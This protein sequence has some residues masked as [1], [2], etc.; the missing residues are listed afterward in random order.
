MV[1]TTVEIGGLRLSTPFV[2]GSG[3]YQTMGGQIRH[4]V[5]KMADNHW[6]GLVTKSYG[7]TQFKSFSLNEKPYL[8][9][10]DELRKVAMENRGPDV[11]TMSEES[12]KELAE[13]VKVMHDR[14]LVI[15][16]NIIRFMTVSEWQ[17]AAELMAA[18]GVDAIEVNAGCPAYGATTIK[19]M[20]E[21]SGIEAPLVDL[22]GKTTEACDKVISAVREVTDKPIFLKLPP[23]DVGDVALAAKNA[24]A[25]GLTLINTIG[26]VMGVDIETTVPLSSTVYGRSFV[27]GLSGPMIKP[28]GLSVVAQLK[29]LTNMPVFGVGG[30]SKWRDAVEYI[31]VGASAVQICTAQMLH[32]FGIGKTMYEGLIAFMEQQNYERISDFE[33][34]SL[35]YFNMPHEDVKA[36][37]SIDFEKCN[38]CMLCYVAC[39][40]GSYEAMIKSGD[41]LAIDASKCDGC[42]LCKVVC[43]VKA[44]VM[45]RID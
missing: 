19:E 30:I 12:M 37:A 26:G 8:W 28:I 20:A 42:G 5:N 27:S 9:T 35:K 38:L 1:D 31:M 13:D 22:V 23:L 2:I 29:L 24:G 3:S 40:E 34:V 17:K 41:S 44:I 7:R 18:T 39:N 14:G 21:D 15:I 16:G 11:G 4:W 43:P 32:G 33:G 10:S 36:V 6:A 45:Q 25:D